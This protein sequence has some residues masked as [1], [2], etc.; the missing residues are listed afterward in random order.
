MATELHVIRMS[1][2]PVNI[3]LRGVKQPDIA[4][5]SGRISG[6]IDAVASPIGQIPRQFFWNAHKECSKSTW[7]NPL[8]L[9]AL[10]HAR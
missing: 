5:I 10:L 2:P 6:K 7:R 8:T 1:K 3:V 4:N 9:V